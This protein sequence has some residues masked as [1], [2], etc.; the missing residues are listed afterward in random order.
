MNDDR[1]DALPTLPPLA[2]P[3]I[4]RP[5]LPPS[6]NATNLIALVLASDSGG[7]GPAL[8]ALLA[9]GMAAQWCAWRFKIPSI[10]L[11]LSLGILVGPV[12][13][14]LSPDALLG[15]LLLPV[16]SLA[17][18][19]IMYEGGLTLRFDELKGTGAALTRLLTI[20]VALTFAGAAVATHFVLGFPWTLSVLM[21]AILTVTGPTVIGPLL[22]HVRPTGSSGRILQWEGIVV[23]PIGA[24]LAVLVFEA[25]VPNSHVTSTGSILLALGKTILVGGAAGLASAW[26]LVRVVANHHV[27][28]YLQPSV[29]LALGLGAFAGSNMLQS[30]SGLLAITVLGIALAN[31]KRFSIRPMLEFKEHLRVILIAGLFLIL[32]ARLSLDDLRDVAVPGMLLVVM[33]ILVVRPLSVLISTMGTKL[34]ARDLVFVA[35][36]APRGIVAASVASIFALRLQAAG[37]ADA[38]ALVPAMFIVIIGTVLVYGF[39]AGPLARWLGLAA[40]DAQGVLIV[41]GHQAVRDIACAMRNAGV[42]VILVDTNRAHVQAARMAKLEAH[43]GNALEREVLDHIDLGGIGRMF[44]MTSNDEVNALAVLRFADLFG[45]QAVFQL[46]PAGARAG[47]STAIPHDLLGRVL[48]SPEVCIDT[49]EVRM[50]DGAVVKSTPLTDRFG[51][52]EWRQMYG[53]DALPLL[54]G[55][56]DK[57]TPWTTDSKLQPKAGDTLVGLVRA[58]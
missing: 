48:F 40:A 1:R 53:E 33:L 27:P 44:A 21:G 51:L 15:D 55:R 52:A 36:V 14:L 54:L 34:P 35:G 12:L 56:S 41:G 18:A 22:R 8:A 2:R 5:V 24:I 39:T 47:K 42:R 38:A 43:L 30:E 37:D 28:E 17:V 26:L 10:V 32:S 23:D 3:R 7:A 58:T 29:S 25:I 13:G 57:I 4:A 16:V 45:R 31:Q 50:V 20:G 19:A 46:A 49:L 6:T 9:L 11:L